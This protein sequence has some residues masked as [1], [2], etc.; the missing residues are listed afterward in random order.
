MY[1]R[2]VCMEPTTKIAE[3]NCIPVYISCGCRCM[4]D[5]RGVAASWKVRPLV[6]AAPSIRDRYY[7]YIA[8]DPLHEQEKSV[9]LRKLSSNGRHVGRQGSM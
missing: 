1:Q 6:T 7:E 9:K 3:R 4:T 5:T 8:I 2:H